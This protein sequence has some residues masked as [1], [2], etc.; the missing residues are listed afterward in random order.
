MNVLKPEHFDLIQYKLDE[1]V[2]P[3]GIGRVPHKIHSKFSGLTADQWR[4]WTNLYS[5]YVLHD[6][7]PSDHYFCWSLLVQASIILCQYSISECDL[8]L[9]DDKLM[10]FC[11]MFEELYGGEKCTPNMHLHGHIKEC[12]FNC[13]PVLTFWAFAFERYNGVLEK[14]VTNWMTPSNK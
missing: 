4:N 5:L 9:E 14:F 11:R 10:Q 7:L 1:M 13:G 8:L 6:I 3:H 12:L 2:V